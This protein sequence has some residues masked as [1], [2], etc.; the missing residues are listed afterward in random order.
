MTAECRLLKKTGSKFVVLHFMNVFLPQSTFAGETVSN[1]S[2]IVVMQK[3]SH[4]N[5]KKVQAPYIWLFRCTLP[6]FHRS[7]NCKPTAAGEPLKPLD[8]GLP[9]AGATVERFFFI[10]KWRQYNTSKELKKMKKREKAGPLVFV[11]VNYAIFWMNSV[12]VVPPEFHW[13]WSRASEWESKELNG[14][15][16]VDKSQ[17]WL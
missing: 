10:F 8:R 12:I 6:E 1:C 16:V 4:G 13:G 15:I 17:I 3:I 9:F 7:D 14:L 2:R 11:E 5:N